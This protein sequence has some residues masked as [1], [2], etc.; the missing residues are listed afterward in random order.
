MAKVIMAIAC[1]AGMVALAFAVRPAHAQGFTDD[2]VCYSWNGGNFSAGSFSKCTHN[3]PAVAA[4]A[5]PA[6]LPPPVVQSPIMMPMS[7]PPPKPVFKPKRKPKPAMTC[8][9]WEPAKK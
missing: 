2:P 8:K 6:P 7:A 4:A 9:A 1:I 3:P 5:P